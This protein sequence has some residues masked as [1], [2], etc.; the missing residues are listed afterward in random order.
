ME[1]L[2]SYYENNKFRLPDT[3]EFREILKNTC[4]LDSN[5]SNIT[6]PQ[7]MW[8]IKKNIF[9]LQKCTI[10]GKNAKFSYKTSS[11][12]KTCSKEC[13]VLYL[14]TTGKSKTE[15]TNMK[16]YGV[17]DYKLTKEFSEKYKITCKKKYGSENFSSSKNFKAI[18]LERYGVENYFETK[19]YIKRFK[20]YNMKAFEEQFHDYK[21]LGYKLIDYK[22]LSK[23]ELYCPHCNS[24]FVTN[25][26][27]EYYKRKKSGHEICTI[28]N[29]LR[30]NY[31]VAEKELAD[32]IR[33]LYEGEILLNDR[34][35]IKNPNTGFFLELDILLPELNLAIEFNGDIW[36]ANPMLYKSTDLIK[37]NMSF[38]DDIWK[39]DL[40]KKKL[41]EEKNIKLITIWE[42]D[43]KHR[44]KVVKLYIKKLIWKFTTKVA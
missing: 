43:W 9:L 34:Y 20:E 5:Y 19:E 36:H 42:R 18:H 6:I 33:S 41:C 13:K 27:S 32:F 37:A 31:S 14:K 17:K 3:K 28:C 8:H 10:C 26:L 40:L 4:F 38:A 24:S 7:R 15:K 23:Y 1:E 2:I 16:K 30:K 25:R 22:G 44:P 35:T 21:E 12:D 29:P 11:Y 39:K